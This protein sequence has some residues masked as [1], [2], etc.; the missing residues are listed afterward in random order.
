MKLE[1]ETLMANRTWTLTSRPENK[2]I[3]TN[4]WVFKLK[5]K[6]DGTMDKYKARLV[7]GGR[8]QEKR[9]DYKEVFSPVVRYE[10]IR[11][12]LAIAVMEEMQANA[13]S[14]YIQG[15]LHEVHMHQSETFITPGREELMCKLQ[16]PLYGLKQ[17]GRE[18]YNEI[19][20]FLLSAGFRRCN[21]CTY[22]HGKRED[23]VNLHG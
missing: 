13:I 5:R 6:Q 15:N 17:S 16:N 10:T 14:V 23:R 12:F 7:M 11:I 18:W 20:S 3:S 19:N 21:S 9:I 8:Q 4:K 22:I 2:K 1:Y